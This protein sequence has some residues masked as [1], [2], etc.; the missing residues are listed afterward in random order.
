MN[1]LIIKLESEMNADIRRVFNPKEAIN[2]PENTLYVKD[3]QQLSNILSSGKLLL[4][5]DLKKSQNVSEVAEKTGRKQEA[6]SRDASILES[7]GLIT[8]TK[9]GRQTY[10]KTKVK[11]IEIDLS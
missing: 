3:A 1:K 7:A 2:L 5:L 10:L 6:I 11:K 4:L 9:K 8:K